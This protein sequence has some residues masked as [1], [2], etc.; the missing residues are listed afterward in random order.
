MNV[1]VM[2]RNWERHT[3]PMPVL[4]P[5]PGSSVTLTPVAFDFFLNYFVYISVSN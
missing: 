3:L 1:G 5:G 4:G 2:Q